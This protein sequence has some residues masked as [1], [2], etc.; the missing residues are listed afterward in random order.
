MA[1]A[2][3]LDGM[4]ALV[5]GG[6]T[7]IGRAVALA[8]AAEGA[9]VTVAWHADPKAAEATVAAIARLGRQA[10]AVR[11]DVICTTLVAVSGPAN[12]LSKRTRPMVMPSTTSVPGSGVMV[13]EKVPV[14]FMV[15]SYVAARSG[16]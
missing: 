2:G 12:T 10:I 14:M 5:T 8:Y 13:I 6:N 3:K 11:A 7:G 16:S 1:N 15:R 9:D 4:K